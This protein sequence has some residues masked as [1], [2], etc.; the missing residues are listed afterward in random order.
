MLSLRLRRSRLSYFLYA[1]SPWPPQG[2]IA[3][4][5]STPSIAAAAKSTVQQ[6]AMIP[7]AKEWRKKTVVELKAELRRR[8]L[9]TTGKKEKA[10]ILGMITLTIQLVTRLTNVNANCGTSE[11]F[12]ATSS[13][14]PNKSLKYHIFNKVL[15]YRV[16][17]TMPS[18]KASTAS[19]CTIPVKSSHVTKTPD[20]YSAPAVAT[21][22][23]VNTQSL[24]APTSNLR[25]GAIPTSPITPVLL[26]KGSFANIR[27]AST[28]APT[29]SPSISLSPETNLLSQSTSTTATSQSQLRHASTMAPGPTLTTKLTSKPRHLHTSNATNAMLSDNVYLPTFTAEVPIE[30]P[31]VPILLTTQRSPPPVIIDTPEMDL[32]I[33]T[34]AGAHT[35]PTPPGGG[36]DSTK[37]HLQ[38]DSTR[39]GRVTKELE[40]Q[41]GKFE[42][43][44]HAAED[45]GTG[46]THKFVPEQGEI[47]ASERG[48]LVGVIGAAILWIFFGPRSKEK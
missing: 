15:N 4:I 16:K 18:T 33:I 25:I 32:P 48:I 42:A 11:A 8:G 37:E 2:Q 23:K 29:K 22:L 27:A 12:S 43:D 44:W 45:G 47:P 30:V 28:L 17:T 9:S 26:N 20:L 24:T 6:P 40:K 36:S 31:R 7:L 39:R 38:S 14:S 3:H 21:I 46:E 34:A 35:H 13:V 41:H 5:Y 1:R 10:L 19:T